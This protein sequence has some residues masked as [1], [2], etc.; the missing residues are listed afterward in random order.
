[1]SQSGTVVNQLSYFDDIA[2]DYERVR[3]TEIW[4]S[5][6]DTIRAIGSYTRQVVD[7]ATGTG[8]FS[9]RLAREGFRV[10]GL[11]QNPHMLAQAIRKAKQQ[12]C[13]F[14]GVLGL[15]EQLPLPE[16][17]VSV[18]FS[19]NAIHH[20]DLQAH[21]QEVRR[22]LRPGGYYV[23]YTRFREQNA[24]SIW[25]QLFPH[26]AEKETRLYNP[27]D[28]ERLEAEYPELALESLDELSFEKPFS[29]DRL[30][31]TTRQRKYS[32]F[33]FYGEEEFW[34]AYATFR[35][36]L[37]SWSDSSYLTQIGRIVFRLR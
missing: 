5:L 7:V 34:R 21:F 1:M 32:T 19:T 23:V 28:F 11:D 35:S 26:F 27:E 20:F 17:S 22:V 15:A 8:L 9:V 12:A 31:Q 36:R 24:N 29:R 13:P 37:E 3:G 14:Q 6:L 30:L 4:A 10:I 16:S 18:V 33:T 2:E 25:G